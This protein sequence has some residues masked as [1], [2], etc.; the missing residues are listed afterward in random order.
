MGQGDIRPERRSRKSST[1]PGS[2]LT[3]ITAWDLERRYQTPIM[4]GELHTP[5]EANKPRYL[6]PLPA[7]AKNDITVDRLSLSKSLTLIPS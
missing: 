3:P 7:P 2:P 1:C 5:P 6:E 4:F